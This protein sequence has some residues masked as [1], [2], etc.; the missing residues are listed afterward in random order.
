MLDV[1]GMCTFHVTYYI[2]QHE[3]IYNVPLMS[4]GSTV[5][6]PLIPGSYKFSSCLPGFRSGWRP[7][8]FIK[9][10]TAFAFID[11]LY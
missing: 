6:S 11:F 5:M 10:E 8:D 2:Y 9:F 4:L 3:I 1:E 7:I